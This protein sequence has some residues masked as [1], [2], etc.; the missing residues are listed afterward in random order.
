MLPLGRGI[1][2]EPDLG[3]ELS[4]AGVSLARIDAAEL[5][6]DD[7]LGDAGA[8]VLHHERMHA[9]A[10]HAK[11]VTRQIVVEVHLVV[12]CRQPPQARQQRPDAGHGSQRGL[13]VFHVS[14]SSR[15][16]RSG[17]SS[18]TSRPAHRPKRQPRDIAKPVLTGC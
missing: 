3:H 1:A 9:A 17:G 12:I 6:N 10:A 8:G 18:L 15:L 14:S 7:A 2:S 16:S 13:V 5:T 4:G 11:S